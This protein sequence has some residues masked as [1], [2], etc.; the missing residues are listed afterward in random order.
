[1]IPRQ[2]VAIGVIGGICASLFALIYR[3]PDLVTTLSNA[4]PI[5][6][7]AMAVTS[8]LL[9]LA[10]GLATPIE[11]EDISVIFYAL[12]SLWG[13]VLAAYGALCHFYDPNFFSTSH[14]TAPQPFVLRKTGILYIALGLQCLIVG[15]LK[16]DALTLLV[17]L[18]VVGWGSCLLYLYRAFRGL[19]DEPVYD[20]RKS[21][22]PESLEEQSPALPDREASLRTPEFY[23][24][25]IIP[26]LFLT[27][28]IFGDE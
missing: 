19:P 13:L 14:K 10:I 26:I 17:Q 8:L 18:V 15:T 20:T 7:M 9:V 11:P 27:L 24:N 3:R 22:P 23:F 5:I 16:E 6:S 12:M 2:I 21:P 4:S 1:M 25:L 28:Y